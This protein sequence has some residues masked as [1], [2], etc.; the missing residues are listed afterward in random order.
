MEKL[1]PDSN[2]NTEDKGGNQSPSWSKKPNVRSPLPN[3]ASPIKRFREYTS[4]LIIKVNK[5][6][7]NKSILIASML[8][9]QSI[10]QL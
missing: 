7:I 10:L 4:V 2:G 6:S 8:L 1:S 9:K 3:S 5:K